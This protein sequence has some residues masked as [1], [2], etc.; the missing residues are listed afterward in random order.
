M[1]NVD[2]I[3]DI[4]NYNNNLIKNILN[5][6]NYFSKIDVNFNKDNLINKINNKNISFF[7]SE[8]NKIPYK[9]IIDKNLE[10][11]KDNLL[12]NEI[13]V[14]NILKDNIYIEQFWNL[15]YIIYQDYIKITNKIYNTNINENIVKINDNEEI[16]KKIMNFIKN[17]L[18]ENYS[19]NK[20]K[21]DFIDLIIYFKNIDIDDISNSELF[22][23]Y[24]EQ[25]NNSNLKQTLKSMLMLL[26]I[27]I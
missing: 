22:D 3:D 16:D 12:F 7:A 20:I 21:K 26:N 9:I 13:D 24:I 11:F 14:I 2:N 8:I 23:K 10:Y 27:S 25:L 17:I 18:T 5:L 1:S 4:K 15:F 19:S 6:I